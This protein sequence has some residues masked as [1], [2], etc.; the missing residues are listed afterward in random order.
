MYLKD[1]LHDMRELMYPYTASKLVESKR[2][3]I[4]D[5][6]SAAGQFGVSHMMIMTQTE[7]GNYM[8]VLKNPRGPTV[9]FKI[10]EYALSKDV[11][12]FGQE[13][14]RNSKIFAKTLQSAPLMIMNGFSQKPEGDVY[15]IVSLMLQSMFPPIKISSMN[16]STCKRVVC[17][18]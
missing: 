14:K 2:N 5:Y 18:T 4:K 15:K 13:N 12:K 1:L 16:L 6:I 8:R 9:T 10:E 11:I 7:Q 3:S 17:L